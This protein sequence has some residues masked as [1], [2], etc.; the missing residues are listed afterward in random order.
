M[1]LLDH[2]PATC[3]RQPCGRCADR[4]QP[5]TPKTVNHRVRKHRPSEPSIAGVTP[6]K[7]HLLLTDLAKTVDRH[8]TTTW[9]HV[10][11]WR[12]EQRIS[13]DSTRG[14]GNGSGASKDQLDERRADHA[15]AVLYDRLEAA[16]ERLADDLITVGHIITEAIPIAIAKA[17]PQQLA[18]Q[19]AAD[20]WCRSCFRD[21][22]HLEPITTRPDG[23]PYH[24]DLCRWCG[25]WQAEHDQLPPVDILAQR[26]A[27]RR[28]RRSA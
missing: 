20:G 11:D 26:H 2:D 3:T 25:T 1:S 7:L 22:Q 17:K 8:G 24:R 18:A 27:G 23:T 19:A 21:D 15:A 13:T 28:I 16:I 9:R 6:T 12:K 5:S 10:D 4:G 14:G